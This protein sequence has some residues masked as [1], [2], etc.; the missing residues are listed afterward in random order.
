MFEIAAPS[1]HRSAG[2][3]SKPCTSARNADAAFEFDRPCAWILRPR[4]IRR[5][6]PP[7]LASLYRNPGRRSSIA[8]AR[9]VDGARCRSAFGGV[10]QSVLVWWWRLDGR[11]YRYRQHRPALFLATCSY[12]TLHDEY[13]AWKGHDWDALDRLAREGVHL[14]PRQQGEVVVFTEQGLAEAE[15]LFHAMFG[16]SAAIK[17]HRRG[18]PM[19]ETTIA[20]QPAKPDWLA[21]TEPPVAGL[22]QQGEAARRR[23][24]RRHAAVAEAA[25]GRPASTSSPTAS[26]RASISC[27]ASLDVPRRHRLR[28]QG[29][30]GHPRRLGTKAMCRPSPPDHPARPAHAT[31]ARSRA[32][33][34]G[35]A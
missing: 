33:T 14:E 31:E 1:P 24:A 10:L 4:A 22:A 5:R 19:L 12:L 2:A 30:D 28:P 9:P 11:R 29:G 32:G 26:N 27:T 35:G 23:Q 18:E 16:K 6:V 25:A 21:G 34:P 15:Q 8:R 13:R 3:L 20:G 17:R 7:R